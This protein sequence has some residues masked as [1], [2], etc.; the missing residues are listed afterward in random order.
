MKPKKTP[1]AIA[2]E[3][4]AKAAQIAWDRIYRGPDAKRPWIRVAKAVK[5]SLRMQKSPSPSR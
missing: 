5:R 2:I 4:A 1:R 3:K